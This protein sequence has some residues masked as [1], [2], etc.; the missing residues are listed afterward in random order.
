MRSRGFA[1]APFEG[2]SPR[3]VRAVLYQYEFAAP[4]GSAW[5]VRRELGL[6]LRPVGKDDPELRAFLQSRGWLD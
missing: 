3:Y 6:W 2:R 4:G 5:W 1:S